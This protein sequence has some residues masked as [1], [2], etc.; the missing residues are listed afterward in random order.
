MSILGFIRKVREFGITESTPADLAKCIR[1]SNEL[2]LVPVIIVSP[3][4][5]LSFASD[6]HTLGWIDLIVTLLMCLSAVLNYFGHITLS[7]LYFLALG[8]FVVFFLADQLGPLSRVVTGYFPLAGMSVLLFT[9]TE[10]LWTYVSLGFHFLASY[11]VVANPNGVLP[12]WHALENTV[13]YPSV[14]FGIILTFAV[15]TYLFFQ[16]STDRAETQLLAMVDQL[17]SEIENRKSAENS[18][19]ASTRLSALG[20]AAG[21][22]AHEINNPL[23]TIT[24]S[25]EQLKE[26]LAE[27]PLDRDAIHQGLDSILRTGKRN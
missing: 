2:G 21:G 24:M 13:I 10:R 4:V 26:I 19:M 9:R 22:I 17:R 15:I 5:F 20:E 23:T 6:N 7:R 8:S 18:A 14:N 27:E 12:R 3:A 25:A 1:L 16:Y 11:V